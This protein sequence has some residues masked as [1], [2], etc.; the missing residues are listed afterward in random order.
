MPSTR[1]SRAPPSPVQD[2]ARSPE[3]PPADAPEPTSR[4]PLTPAEKKLAKQIE[5]LVERAMDAE[6]HARLHALAPRSAADLKAACEF[7]LELPRGR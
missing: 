5:F 7:A 4:P 1:R 3:P 2:A 6:K